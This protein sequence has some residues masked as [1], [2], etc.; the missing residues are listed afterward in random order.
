MINKTVLELIENEAL[1]GMLSNYF[2]EVSSY[3]FMNFK[4]IAGFESI[5]EDQDNEVS[6]FFIS[7]EQLRQSITKTIERKEGKNTWTY[8]S[9]ENQEL[10]TDYKEQ[11]FDFLVDILK[12]QLEIQDNSVAV[13]ITYKLLL[14][15]AKRYFANSWETEYGSYFS[16]ISELS[17]T[18]ATNIYLSIETIN[19]KNLE[20]AGAFIY[21][22]MINGK[23]ESNNYLDCYDII[24]DMIEKCDKCKK[25][26]IFAE[27][28]K[29][30]SEPSI[31]TIDSIDIMDGYEFENFV[32]DLFNKMGYATIIT[33]ASG[34]Q[35]VDVIAEKNGIRIGIQAKCY[36]GKVPNSAIQQVVAGISYHNCKKGIVVTNSYFTESAKEIANSNNIVLWDRLILKE[37]IR[38]LY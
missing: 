7:T 18:E 37:K 27:R 34:D 36:S 30:R 23:F 1:Y 6:M 14:E 25:T 28:L 29:N 20:T 12:Q 24:V 9:I 4:L 16:D 22:L 38:E 17:I 13:Y 21:Y 35:G 15:A 5:L 2:E 26:A 32:A 8:K 33:K 31:L 3:F 19:P 10:I 11:Y